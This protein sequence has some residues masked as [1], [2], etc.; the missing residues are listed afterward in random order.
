MRGPS[1]N[2]KLIASDIRSVLENAERLAGRPVLLSARDILDRMS[3][4]EQLLA[5]CADPRSS[6][7]TVHAAVAAITRT[8]ITELRHDV[9]FD[10][11]AT[12]TAGSSGVEPTGGRALGQMT[13]VYGLVSS[14]RPGP[15]AARP[16][17]VIPLGTGGA[18]VSR[19][20]RDEPAPAPPPQRE[21]EGWRLMRKLF[22]VVQFSSKQPEAT[23][24]TSDSPASRTY[25]KGAVL[26]I[27]DDRDTRAA[28]SELLADLGYWPMTM[29]NGLEALEY[30]RLGGKPVA[31]LVDLYMPLMDGAAFCAACDADPRLK[32]IP[33]ILISAHPGDSSSATLKR[34]ASVL[35]KPLSGDVLEETLRPFALQP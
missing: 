21:G 29:R 23:A 12:P 20:R 15:S 17:A 4:R 14:R 8:L 24:A 22:T 34:V 9:H 33:R 1:M 28:A 16:P 11:T 18:E 7:R 2:A 31:I 10:V 26:I 27:D 19:T 35:P 13:A 32:K 6:E 25:N 5:E 30:L 3:W